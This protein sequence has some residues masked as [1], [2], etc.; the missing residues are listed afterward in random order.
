VRTKRPPGAEELRSLHHPAEQRPVGRHAR[1][2]GRPARAVPAAAAAR[3]LVGAPQEQ[4]LHRP[5]RSLQALRQAAGHRPLADQPDVAQCGEVNL[6][7]H[8]HRVPDHQRRR[9]ADQGARKYKEYGINEKP[10]V[11]V[12][13]D[14][15]TY[16][17]GIMTVRDAKDLDA[18]NRKTKQQDEHHQ[19][20]PGA[21]RDRVIIQE[22]VLTNERVNDGVAEPVV[23]M[24]DRYVVGGFYRVHAERGPTRTSTRR[25]PASCRWPSPR[26]PP[27]AA[28]RQAR[29]QR[30][31][32]L[33]HVRRDRPA[34][35]A[36][37]QLRAGSDRP[38]RRG[39]RLKL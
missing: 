33:L 24:M 13:A 36:G 31:E 37:R 12:K 9:A 4:P 30:P 7:E 32:P 14:N 10:F 18:L 34:G 38:G 17:M 5:T 16:G 21:V 2:P 3:G 22:G 27:A 15:G 29:R 8:R 39:L 23:Y 20:R 1:H 19:G 6:A 25:A 11:V 26:A 28:R 35:H